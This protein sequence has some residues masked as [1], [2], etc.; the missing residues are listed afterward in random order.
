MSNNRSKIKA[1]A[2]KNLERSFEAMKEK[3]DKAL[4]SGAVDLDDWDENSN[5]MILP[6]IITKAI[7]EDEADQYSAKGT[8]FHREVIKEVRNLKYF[9]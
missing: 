8:A 1:L 9:I 3:V 5:P 7:L 4:D 2:I 6:K